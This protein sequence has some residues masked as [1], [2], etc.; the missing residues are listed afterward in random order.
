[1]IYGFSLLLMVLGLVVAIPA[2]RKLLYMQ[3]IRNKSRIILGRVESTKSAM[4]TAGWLMGAVSASE[5]VNHQRPLVTYRPLEGKEMSVDVVPSTF[6]SRRKYK[7]GEAVEVAF[8]QSEPWRAF[9]V[10]EWT[11]AAR[12]LWI[13]MT[14]GATAVILW[15]VGRVYNLPF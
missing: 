1:M 13:G 9:L 14:I 6:L 10:R 3:S 15:I 7:V 5:M 2:L 8:D 11:A 4:N 12:D